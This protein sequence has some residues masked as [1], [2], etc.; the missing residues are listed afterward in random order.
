[1]KYAVDLHIHSALSPCADKDM[2]PNNIVNMALL[3]ELDIIAVCD[4]NSAGNAEA[5]CKCSAGRNLLAVPAME[6]ETSEEVHLVCLLPDAAAALR[7]QERIYAALPDKANREDIFGSQYIMDAEDNITGSLNK[8]LVTATSLSIQEVFGL[9][10]CLGGVVIPAHIDRSSYSVISNL[11]FIPEDLGINYVEFS[12]NC[13]TVEFLRKNPYLEKYK[14]IR[15]SDA[16][17]LGD[18][19]EREVFIE[20]DELSIECLFSELRKFK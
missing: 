6:I 5:V 18:I 2:T 17:S 20:L 9:A 3:K 11:G 7:L 16:H 10:A 1:M 8:L 15:S 4:H 13:D 12:K 19:L 14:F